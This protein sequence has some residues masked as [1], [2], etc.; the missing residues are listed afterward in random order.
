MKPVFPHI[1][2][3]PENPEGRPGAIVVAEPDVLLRAAID[4]S[5]CRDR[6]RVQSAGTIRRALKLVQQGGE[7]V[8]L[9]ISSFEFPAGNGLDLCHRCSVHSPGTLILVMVNSLTDRIAAES[10]G[11]EV[12]LK[13]FSA[14]TLRK[15]VQFLLNRSQPNSQPNSAA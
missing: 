2:R 13:P 5:L 7:P 15:K 4:D 8:D 6:H 11:W 1:A 3:L 9:L 14:A 10:R 12:L